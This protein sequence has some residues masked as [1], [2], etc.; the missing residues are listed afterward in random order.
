MASKADMEHDLQLTIGL[1]ATLRQSITLLKA[2]KTALTAER[3][4]LRAEV[5]RLN[6]LFKAGLDFNVLYQQQGSANQLN[7]G[8]YVLKSPMIGGLWFRS[9]F[10]GAGKASWNGDSFIALVGVQKGLFKF[11]YSYD[12][13]IS[14]LTNNATAG[15]HEISFGIQFECRPKKKR[16]RTIQCPTF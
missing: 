4:Q 10:G 6:A 7:L 2:D 3:D 12:V 9:N 15:S 5:E 16:F 14:K 11:G 8:V 13:T 1:N